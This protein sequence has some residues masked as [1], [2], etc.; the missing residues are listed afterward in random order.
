M[1]T[2][3]SPQQKHAWFNLA[4]FASALAAYLSLI[5]LIG[6]SR[7][8][9]AFGIC[10]VWGLGVFFYR[11]KRAH[12]VVDERDEQIGRRSV[13]VAYAAFWLFFVA[14]CMITWGV[15][16]WRGQNSISIYVLPNL[17]FGGMFVVVVTQS[18]ATLAQYGGTGSCGKE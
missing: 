4:V 16:H 15:L 17:V 18:V 9:G 10:G 3:M 7:A 11:K 14:T 12:L 13:L 5:P 1:T 6:V 8:F 2:E